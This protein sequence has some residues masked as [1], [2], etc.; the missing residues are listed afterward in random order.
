MY[1]PHVAYRLPRG[2]VS[3]EEVVGRYYVGRTEVDAELVGEF[4]RNDRLATGGCIRREGMVA[5]MLCGERHSCHEACDEAN[6]SAEYSR[7]GCLFFHLFQV[8]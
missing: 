2:V 3:V 7:P 5:G 4:S 6:A 1:R 8:Q